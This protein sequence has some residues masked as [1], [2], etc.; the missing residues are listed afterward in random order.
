MQTNVL[1]GV[2][3]RF[4]LALKPNLTEDEIEKLFVPVYEALDY[5]QAGLDIK[6]K[7]RGRAGFPDVLLLDSVEGLPSDVFVV[8]ELKR[9]SEDLE[10]HANQLFKYLNELN[11][12]WG[13]LSNGYEIRIYQ[14]TGKA[15]DKAGQFSIEDLASSPEPLIPLA[16]RFLQVNNFKQVEE[17]VKAARESGMTLLEIEDVSSAR[18]IQTFALEANT[19]FGEVVGATQELLTEL[20]GQSKFVDGSYD[21][22]KRLYARELSEDDVPKVW[23]PFLK[24]KNREDIYRFMFSLETAYTLTARLI[25]A[26]AVED[27]DRERHLQQRV[28]TDVLLDNIGYGR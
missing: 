7:P 26:K 21:F 2:L 25:L 14:R 1:R 28:L 27:Q 16:K 18:F 6:G 13:L 5:Q 11:A 9:P 10:R 12:P 15:I 3:T 19:P 8:V 24:T 22:W 4:Q 23:L 20:L 17:R